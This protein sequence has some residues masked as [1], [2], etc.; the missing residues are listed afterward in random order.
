MAVNLTTRYLFKLYAGI[1]ST[2]DDA[3]IDILIDDASSQI[4]EVCQRTFELTTYKLWL[5]GNGSSMLLLPD[6]PV[7]V[8]YKIA[9]DMDDV[10]DV[11]FEGSGIHAD[12]TVDDTNCTLHYV[13]NSGDEQTTS[14][15]LSTYKTAT[16]LAAAINAVSG[17]TATLQSAYANEATLFLRPVFGANTLSTDY[18]TLEV[19][20]DGYDVILD[21]ET[22]RVVRRKNARTF[23]CG[24]SNIFC[25]F[26]AGYTLPV[27]NSEHTGLDT[28]GDVPKGLTLYTNQ[29]VKKVYKERK[30]DVSLKSEKIDDYSY[31]RGDISGVVSAVIE[32]SAEDLLPYTK[33]ET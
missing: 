4:A 29:V 7:T 21:S 2:T 1:T 6:W 9:G 5:D 14:L 18:V 32:Q 8:V 24:Y 27:D 3:L 20:D 16:T 17:W 26:K 25:W 11:E 33:V 19:P 28:D 22:D 31:T 10:M 23:P 12:V 30:K 13:D 15:A